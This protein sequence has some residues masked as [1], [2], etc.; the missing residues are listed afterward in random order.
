MQ[1]IFY[2]LVNAI[3]WW[4]FF[5][6]IDPEEIKQ[7]ETRLVLWKPER[8]ADEGKYNFWTKPRSEVENQRIVINIMCALIILIFVEL[9]A[10]AIVTKCKGVW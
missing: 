3:D 9:V 2:T 8:A 1:R 5:C 6:K 4:L 7:E 10:L